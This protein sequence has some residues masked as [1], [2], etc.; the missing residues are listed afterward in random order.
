MEGCVYGDPPICELWLRDPH[1]RRASANNLPQFSERTPGAFIE[2]REA[3][4]VWR[5]WTGDKI[6]SH[7]SGW[8]WA[9]RQAAEAQ[10]HIF[11]SLGERYGLRIIP[12]STSFLVLPNNISRSTAVGAI[13]HP[14]GPARNQMTA[15]AAWLSPDATEADSTTEFDFVLAVGKD[16]K[17]MRRLNELDGAETCSTRA[18]KGTD[19]KWSL[20]VDQVVPTLWR[21]AEGK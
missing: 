20:N 16:E 9:H 7:A 6:D 21:F 5:F 12:G 2:E 18:H 4:V 13:L 17:L 19:A 3:S 14:G 8:Q 11:D 1:S 10:N 15:R